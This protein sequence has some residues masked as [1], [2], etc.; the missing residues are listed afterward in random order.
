MLDACAH[1]I[2]LDWNNY[3]NWN[4]GTDHYEIVI[5]ESSC[6]ISTDDIRLEADITELF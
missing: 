1:T 5:N 2:S 3:V 6:G 4:G